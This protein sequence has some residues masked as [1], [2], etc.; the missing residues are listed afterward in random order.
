MGS[1]IIHTWLQKA[2]DSGG[3]EEIY[4]TVDSHVKYAVSGKNTRNIF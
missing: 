4:I 1:V 3:R 2:K